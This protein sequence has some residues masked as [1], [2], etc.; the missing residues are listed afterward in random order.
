MEFN[1]QKQ[2]LKIC[3]DLEDLPH[4]L[5]EVL[6]SI[7][8]N[9]NEWYVIVS[10]LMFTN[11]KVLDLL[12]ESSS[13]NVVEKI[14]VTLEK[15]IEDIVT[16]KKKLKEIEIQTEEICKIAVKVD[17]RNLKYVRKPNVELYR[18]AVQKYGCALQFVDQSCTKMTKEETEQ[19]CILALTKDFR[20]LKD[21]TG[22][23]IKDGE[24]YFKL[25]KIAIERDSFAIEYV[26][27]SSSS[28]LTREQL[29][30]LCKIAVKRN[31]CVIRYIANFLLSVLTQEQLYELCKI[32][33][34]EDGSI[35]VY[36][37]CC[38]RLIKRDPEIYYRLCKLAVQKNGFVVKM[39]DEKFRT[40]E[41]IRIAAKQMYYSS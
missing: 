36:D 16:E 28:I 3:E 25:C 19:I 18:L 41:L 39:I 37:Y 22:A 35:A 30:E 33:T 29:Y 26:D 1:F 17:Y 11:E 40:K 6:S 2:I 15:D 13:A 27:K 31:S 7:K 5:A 34:E 14:R 20:S 24:Q 23:M 9:R 21:L 32:S 4:L 38:A 10:K 8:L 12:L